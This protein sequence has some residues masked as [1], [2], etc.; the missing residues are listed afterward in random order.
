[1]ALFICMKDF[2]NLLRYIFKFFFYNT[3]ISITKHYID[4]LLIF[5]FF[6]SYIF[7]FFYNVTS[8]DD[9]YEMIYVLTDLI[10][11]NQSPLKLLT[12]LPF[13]YFLWYSSVTDNYNEL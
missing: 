3:T 11:F 13:N 7:N 10:F 5:T 6:F 12:M 8:P 1:M 9:G 4:I 2:N